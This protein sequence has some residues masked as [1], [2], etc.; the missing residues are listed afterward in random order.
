MKHEKLILLGVVVVLMLCAVTPALAQVG[1][2]REDDYT[3]ELINGTATVWS[4]SGYD[5][6]AWWEYDS[7]WLNVWFYN[8]PWDPERKKWI[9][10][11]MTLTPFGPGSGLTTEII[12]GTSTP[13]WSALALGRPPLPDDFR[14]GGILD[15]F[16]EDYAINRTI[17]GNQVFLGV[18]P[19]LIVID[20]IYREILDENPEWV[21]IDVWV[22]DLPPDFSIN[23]Y[24]DHQC[25]PEPFTVGLLGIGLMGLIRKRRKT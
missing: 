23:G 9:E 20:P 6:G 21:F 15:G 1:P 14:L 2:L 17:P 19:E 10:I 13:D 7:G 5:N 25:I 18:I 8:D 12:W 11:G 16:S 22:G 24:I 3:V 4:G